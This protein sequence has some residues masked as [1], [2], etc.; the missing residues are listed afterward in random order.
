MIEIIN[1]FNKCVLDMRIK[2]KNRNEI[3]TEDLV[4]KEPKGQFKVWFAEACKMSQI[5]KPNAVL[6]G[7]ATK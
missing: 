3:F 7:T 6:L 2:Y 1:S 5:F 4:S